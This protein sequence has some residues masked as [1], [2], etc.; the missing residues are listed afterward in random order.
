MHKLNMIADDESVV[1]GYEPATHTRKTE[2]LLTQC[3]ANTRLKE[4][5]ALDLPL[6]H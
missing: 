4:G 3:L 6:M 5:H 1:P 2:T